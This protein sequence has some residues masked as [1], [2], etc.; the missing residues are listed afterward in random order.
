MALQLGQILV[1]I[2]G[3]LII[4]I[5]LIPLVRNDNWI[6]RIFE[7][8]R[9]QKL[10][11]NLILLGLFLVIGTLDTTHAIVFTVLLTANLGY[12]FYQI[13]PYT[14][15]AGKQMKEH[16]VVQGKRQF[17]LMV[18]NVF[19]DN[20]DVQKT[21]QCIA[22]CKPDVIILVETDLWWKNQLR[23][24]DSDYPHQVSKPLNNTYGMLLFSKFELIDPE[25]RFLI[26]PEIP[27]IHTKVRMASG[28]IFFLYCLHPQPPVPQENPRS[29]ERDAEILTIAKEAKASSL[30]VIVAGD[31]N[32]VAWSYTTELFMKVSGLLDPRRGRGFFST[33][34]AKYWFLR[35]PLDHIFCS[36]HFQLLN[37]KVL[38][39][40]GSDHFP[41]F[42]EL[43]LPDK[44][45]SENEGKAL[46]ADAEDVE[47]AEEKIGQAK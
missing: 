44:P 28:D 12:L 40:T 2:F 29:T 4:A 5:S 38:P 8:P 36:S 41:I 23:S 13:F 16:H 3:Y 27:S 35:W 39:H 6:F 20:R 37:L 43:I 15:I 30:P 32:D 31:L 47:M 1:Y 45:V 34:H 18:S 21:L 19:Q 24:L 7:Y 14:Q 10:L 9:S 25:V 46:Q 22:G 42:V 17:R 11:I 33:F 26:D